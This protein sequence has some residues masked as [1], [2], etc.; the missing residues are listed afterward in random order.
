MTLCKGQSQ[1][2]FISWY[3]IEG[4]EQYWIW[5]LIC[6]QYLLMVVIPSVMQATEKGIKPTSDSQVKLARCDNHYTSNHAQN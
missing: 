2:A 6:R 3:T 4:L 5:V 1:S